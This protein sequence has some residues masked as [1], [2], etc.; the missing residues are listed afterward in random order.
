MAQSDGQV[1]F[2]VELDDAAFQQG[3]ARL[4]ATLNTLSQSMVTAFTLSSAQL[5][6]AGSAGAQWA[7]RFA[8]GARGSGAV[9]AAA[10]TVV[11]K[12]TSAARKQGLSGGI[13][14]GQNIVAGMASGA[15]S[16][17]GVL[18][19]ALAAII[20]AALAA[21]RRAA[22]IASPSRLFHDEVGRYL[23]LGVQSG[24]TDTM[25]QSVLPAI[26]R[27]VQ[28]GAAAGLQSL[29]PSLL[30]NVQQALGAKLAV[31]ITARLGIAG[32]GSALPGGIANDSAQT[33]NVTQNIAFS[34]TMQAPDE[35]ARAIRRQT[36]YGLAAARS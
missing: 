35:I 27:S 22:G 17:S 26:G 18:N 10:Q 12:A 33:V 23:A 24:F 20:A 9:T 7:A 25:A 30:Q 28:S 34:S 36:T 32:P 14:V 13:G 6:G 3:M 31:P 15:L 2:T 16:K 1:V 19:A 4:Q 11:S 29:D 21:A 5:D 8:A